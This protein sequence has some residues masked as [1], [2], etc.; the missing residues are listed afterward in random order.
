MLF[1]DLC[2]RTHTR[3]DEKQI[4]N[5]EKKSHTKSHWGFKMTKKNQMQANTLQIKLFFTHNKEKA[6]QK[7]F[8]TI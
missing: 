1:V 6:T 2:R 8:R 3:R 5:Q 7:R 4:A